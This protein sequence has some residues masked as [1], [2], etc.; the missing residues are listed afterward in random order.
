MTLYCVDCCEAEG[1]PHRHWCSMESYRL[2]QLKAW[3]D[4]YE[5]AV[6]DLMDAVLT[7]DFIGVKNPFTHVDSMWME[8]GDE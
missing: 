3:H 2:A 5:T 1:T 4:G 6:A 7:R 8:M